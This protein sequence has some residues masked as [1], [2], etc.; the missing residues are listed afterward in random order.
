MTTKNNFFTLESYQNDIDL[1]TNEDVIVS[2]YEDIISEDDK[3]KINF[4]FVT[5]TKHKADFFASKINSSYEQYSNI[6]INPYDELFEITGETNEIQMTLDNI[7]NWNQEM[8]DFGYLYDCK[9]DG[10]HVGKD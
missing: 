4:A 9:L 2:M 3:L 6:K 7:N 10:W 1:E 5:D 8:W